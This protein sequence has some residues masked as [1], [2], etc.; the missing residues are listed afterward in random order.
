M[1]DELRAWIEREYVI[2]T[3]GWAAER[4]GRVTERLQAN[5]PPERRLESLVVWMSDHGAF[6]ALGRTVYISRRL[7]E[8]LPDDDAAAFVIAHEIAHHRLGHI[9]GYLGSSLL[10]AR[11]V[12][13]VIGSLLHSSQHEADA[14][15]L[16]IELCLAA[17]YDLERCLAAFEHL[18]MVSLDYGDV[19]GVLGGGGRRSHPALASR[20]AAVREHARAG[21]Q[22][23]VERAREREHARRR[24]RV[25]TAA[26]GAAAAT[27]LLLVLRRP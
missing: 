8:R 19:D 17:G 7:L 26:L 13:A 6:T 10:P 23:D 5:V 22:L 14:D 20:I 25:W 4:V 18:V 15:R 11:I 12:L 2:E 27:A 24:R 9:P 16:A 1:T 3:S 21:R